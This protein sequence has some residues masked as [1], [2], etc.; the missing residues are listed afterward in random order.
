MAAVL[1][2]LLL[3]FATFTVVYINSSKKGKGG[4]N[5]ITSN[6][7]ADN[8]NKPPLKNNTVQQNNHIN[9]VDPP[10]VINRKVNEKLIADSLT[11]MDDISIANEEKRK[12]NNPLNKSENQKENVVNRY[13]GQKDLSINETQHLSLQLKSMEP[14]IVQ[15]ISGEYD[16]ARIKIPVFN[17]RVIVIKDTLTGVVENKPTPKSKKITILFIPGFP[18][19]LMQPRKLL[20]II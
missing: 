1:L 11:N 15:T 4:N 20:A 5:N 3:G 16:I 2:F 10:M 7:N 9:S 17:F 12:I 18:S 13:G 19:V 6:S 8:K 14:V